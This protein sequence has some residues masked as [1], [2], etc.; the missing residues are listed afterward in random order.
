[1]MPRPI[2]ETLRE[3]RRG[4]FLDEAA[5][6]LHELVSAVTASGKG[7]TLTLRL[8]VQPAGRGNAVRTVIVVDQITSNLPAPDREVT[9]F[10][11]TEAG[12]LSR[13]DPSQLPLGLRPVE[14]PVQPVQPI[15]QQNA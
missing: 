6:K 1:M 4:A 9:V 8:T 2:L 15:A 13:S 10:F 14:T 5:E 11:P 3:I 12:E 7:G